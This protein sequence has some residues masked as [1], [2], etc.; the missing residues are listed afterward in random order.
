MISVSIPPIQHLHN[1]GQRENPR[2]KIRLNRAGPPQIPLKNQKHFYRKVKKYMNW[3]KVSKS[4][5]SSNFVS[6]EGGTVAVLH[7]A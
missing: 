3:T 4:S 6:L 5:K 2:W 7:A 1:D